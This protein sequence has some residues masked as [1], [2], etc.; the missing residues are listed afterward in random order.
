VGA[1]GKYCEEIIRQVEQLLE[2]GI[3]NKGVME[4]IGITEGTFYGWIKK[5]PRPIWECKCKVKGKD[6]DGKSIE[7]NKIWEELPKESICNKCKKKPTKK[8]K[9]L[10]RVKRAKARGQRKLLNEL[11]EIGEK[12][13]Q[14][15]AWMLERIWHDEFGLKNGQSKKDGEKDIEPYEEFLKRFKKEK[16]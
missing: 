3:S 15:R 6:L 5:D 2:E 10:N 4:A 14:S 13:W 11:R 1:K 12:S 7:I 8:L 16:V 9:F